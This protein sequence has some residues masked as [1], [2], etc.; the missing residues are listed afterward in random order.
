[1]TVPSDIT[2]VEATEP[3]GATVSYP[4]ATATDDVGVTSGPTCTPLSG[5]TFSVGTTTVTCTA[6]DAAVYLASASFTVTV[7]DT[8]SPA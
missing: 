7:V 6:S 2:D 1:M 3:T 4:P 8:T 5:T